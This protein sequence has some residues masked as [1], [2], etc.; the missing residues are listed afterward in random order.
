MRLSERAPGACF[1]GCFRV[2]AASSPVVQRKTSEMRIPRSYG[3]V[4][5]IGR[6]SVMDVVTS[7]PSDGPRDRRDLP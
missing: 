2:D 6:I 1:T 5:G 3:N 7:P 4:A